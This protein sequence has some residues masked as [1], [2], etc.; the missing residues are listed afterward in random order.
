MSAFDSNN[1]YIV[2]NVGIYL[3]LSKEDENTGQSE[4]IENQR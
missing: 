1:N 4:S 3:R 2:Y